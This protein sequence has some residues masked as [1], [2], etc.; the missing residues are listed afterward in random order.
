MIFIFFL[1]EKVDKCVIWSR[2]TCGN[3]H[4]S[5]IGEVSITYIILIFQFDKVLL[6]RYHF[7][8]TAPIYAVRTNQSQGHNSASKETYK[9][10]SILLNKRD[11]LCAN[12]LRL[13][14]LEIVETDY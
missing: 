4:F 10:V 9:C 3:H 11:I 12:S 5:E 7:C 13:F 6:C 1:A 8:L 14:S 2:V